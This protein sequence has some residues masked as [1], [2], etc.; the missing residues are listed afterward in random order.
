MIGKGQ[1]RSSDVVDAGMAR[2]VVTA[3]MVW[4]NRDGSQIELTFENGVLAAKTQ[5]GLR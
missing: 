2:P 1:G 4:K 3:V 5:V